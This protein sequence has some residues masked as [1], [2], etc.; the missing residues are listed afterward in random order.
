[1]IYTGEFQYGER[2]GEGILYDKKGN[3]LDKGLWK[4]DKKIEL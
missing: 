1:M 3:E 2:N 4:D